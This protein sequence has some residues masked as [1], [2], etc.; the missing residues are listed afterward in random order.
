MILFSWPKQLKW[1]LDRPIKIKLLY[2]MKYIVIVLLAAV[3][4]AQFS[5]P[6]IAQIGDAIKNEVVSVEQKIE[7]LTKEEI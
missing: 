3:V 4:A 2:V 1:S 5:M 6:D 7:H